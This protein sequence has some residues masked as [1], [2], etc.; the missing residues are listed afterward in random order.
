MHRESVKNNEKLLEDW[1]MIWWKP[2]IKCV[3]SNY[4]SRKL[5]TFEVTFLAFFFIT[6]KIN[7]FIKFKVYFTK[8]FEIISRWFI[9]LSKTF[10]YKFFIN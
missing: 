2:V 6:F 8:T 5:Y 4:K 3:E 10:R 7:S 9:I 1:S